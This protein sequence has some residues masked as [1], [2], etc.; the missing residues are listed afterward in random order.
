MSALRSA[1]PQPHLQPYSYTTSDISPLLFDLLSPHLNQDQIWPFYHTYS[2]YLLFAKPRLAA[3]VTKSFGRRLW[4]TYSTQPK[5]LV[6]LFFFVSLSGVCERMEQRVLMVKQRRGEQGVHQ[7]CLSNHSRGNKEPMPFFF[8]NS[9]LFSH[10]N[11][12]SNHK[13]GQQRKSRPCGPVTH[14]VS[15]VL[16]RTVLKFPNL[17]SGKCSSCS[18][19]IFKSN[20]HV[21]WIS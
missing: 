11:T 18:G 13:A 14:S 1:W 9:L 6:L 3:S 15:F 19:C 16:R 20:P 21:C 7:S 5:K 12:L 2:C 17:K 4:R 8:L 10:T